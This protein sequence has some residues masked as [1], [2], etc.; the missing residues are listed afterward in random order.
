MNRSKTAWIISIVILLSLGGYLQFH[1]P[2][3]TPLKMDLQKLPLIVGGWRWVRTEV[4]PKDFFGI[5]GADNQLVSVYKNASGHEIKLYIAYFA[6]QKQN[7]KVI[8][9]HS[10]WLHKRTDLVE[11]PINP[12]GIIRINKTIFRG[13]I[14]NQLL[15]FW[16][17]L[18]G[19][20]ITNRYKAQ[21]FAILYGLFRGRTNGAII[22]ISRD[23][24]S[25]DNIKDTLNEETG[26][27]RE[28]LPVLPS[29]LP[30]S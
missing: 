20:I 17:D 15:L 12:H 1:K 23:I 2:F 22:I 9:Y 14:D 24:G 6:F 29:Y 30:S 13:R 19:R 18:N 28:L 21:F 10:K 4:S 25:R 27:I 26:F 7:K 11:I 3:P 5:N 8:G 16:Y